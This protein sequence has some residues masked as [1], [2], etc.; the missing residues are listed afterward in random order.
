MVQSRK[1]AKRFAAG[2]VVATAL[3]ALSLANWAERGRF[4][5]PEDGVVWSDSGGS[6]VALRVGPESPGALVGVRPGDILRSIGGRPVAEALDVPRIL[7]DAGAW[8]RTEYGISRGGMQIHLSVVLGESSSRGA[9][10][11]FLLVL[12]LLYAAIGLW[13]WLRG[14]PGP[15]TSRFL[16]FCLA[17]LA[18]YSLSSTG[19]LE[20]LDRLVYWLDVWGLLLMPPL[21]LDFCSR[22]AG[23]PSQF[24]NA[25]S[26]AYS[27][28]V[29]TGAAHHAAAGGWVGGGIGDPA[30]LWFFDTASLAL[31]AVNLA[32]A[33]ALVG[34][35]SRQ[36]KEPVRLLQ[37]RWLLL[38]IVVAVVPFTGL[39]V[40]PFAAG[41]APGPNQAFSVLSLAALPL[42]I[43]VALF[44][45]RLLD[46]EALRRKTLASAFAVGLLGAFVYAA[47]FLSGIPAAWLDRFAPLFWMGSLALAAAIYRPLHS[48]LARA[49]ERRAFRGRYEDRRTLGAFARELATESNRERMAE[50]ASARLSRTLN[51]ERV[52]LL[53]PAGAKN[54]AAQEFH[55]L[56][57][58]EGSG[59]ASTTVDMSAVEELARSQGEPVSVLGPL[60]A[61]LPGSLASL[62]CHHF[63]RCRV[64]ER[65]AAWIAVGPRRDGAL[66][67]G[68][69]LSLVEAL[70]APFAI[71]LE[72]AS[73][74]ASL[75]AKAAQYQRLK[76][77]NENI[78]ESLSVGILVLD[79]DGRVQSW[80]TH[81]ELALQISRDD[82]R[83]RRLAEL[84]PPGLVSAFERCTDES[85]AGTIHKFPLRAREFPEGFRPADP[86][87]D[88]VRTVNVAVA[89]LVDKGFRRIG[90]LLILDDV[91]E[92]VELE[93]RVVQADKL[94]SVGLLAAGVA[95]EVNT[96]LAV[97][98]SYSQMLA[99]RVA[100]GSAEAKILG[101]VTEQTF[102]A[103]EI[104]NSLLDFSR[105][106]SSDMA[107][108]DINRVI[109]DTVDLLGPQL[110][111]AG[112]AVE[113]DL[114][115]PAEILASRGKLQ[116]VFLNLFLNAR[117][118]MAGG[119]S[120][121]LSSRAGPAPVGEEACVRVR[122]E[123]T[124]AGIRPEDQR[125]I[126]DPFFTT[127]GPREGTGLGLAVTYG[128]VREHS[129]TI[130]VESEPGS[131]TTFK[132]RFPL[133]KRPVHA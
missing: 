4:E 40:L 94:S 23:G 28:A 74:Y 38:G 76:D 115:G 7:A 114:L 70:S 42:A 101:K 126:F 27:A 50:A 86:S 14:P 90:Q 25:T 99:E 64:R 117:D 43:A 34:M 91:T 1:I 124:G 111:Q 31:L 45:Y 36:I 21:L 62:G 46:L 5:V 55:L 71:A 104:V 112:V 68:E 95:H 22:F 12:G 26:I 59:Q 69:D 58:V 72:N 78:V 93:Q 133:A 33:A 11:T 32:A 15:A 82:A 77:Y 105:T 19:R 9:L 132:L 54:S 49:L 65:T 13:V 10:G 106:S 107:V 8:S 127:K 131:G 66:L 102:R 61:A 52:A 85:G 6:V 129:G 121:R 116:Q 130:S 35:Q 24:R 63:V 73:L 103:S 37:A 20:G 56:R 79:A 110:R 51:T 3:V 57:G 80:N 75:E 84:L 120:L 67:S 123:D 125:R 29:A 92:Q 30:L 60:E 118:A 96:P 122:I 109:E 113:S 44:R 17:S 108:C 48:W 2:A 89:P 18:V 119:G 100:R 81:L 128:I 41:L 97:I 53:V 98:C 39:Y 87:D 83:G 47:L 16:A 88:A